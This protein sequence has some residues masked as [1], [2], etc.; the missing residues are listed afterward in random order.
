MAFNFARVKYNQIKMMEARGYTL[1]P[2]DF[3]YVTAYE[4]AKNNHQPVPPPD[5]GTVT[6]L[7][8]GD[9]VTV[10]YIMMT[11][12]VP[13]TP[14]HVA[15][16]ELINSLAPI[17]AQLGSSL[18]HLILVSDPLNAH[19]DEE[20]LTMISRQVLRVERFTYEELSIQAVKHHFNPPHR[21]LTKNE[22]AKLLKDAR[23]R[24]ADLPKIR[25]T[26]KIAKWYGAQPSDV[27]VFYPTG[28]IT[29][30]A[31]PEWRVVV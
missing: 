7:K 20:L 25:V 12:K 11:R 8:Q 17:Q 13:T 24:L 14:G 18:K 31:K 26:D 19:A 15:K 10:V 5:L 16:N 27:L 29:G 21:L 1:N 22:T 28:P 4:T 23:S 9:I 2:E 3:N 6:Y 30:M